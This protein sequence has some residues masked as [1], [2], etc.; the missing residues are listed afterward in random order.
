MEQL[1]EAF[2]IDLRLIIIQVFNFGILMAALT[3]FLYKPVLKMLNEREEKIAQGMKDAQ[4]AGA[5][6]AEATEEKKAVIAAANKEAEA[7]TARAKDH[8]VVK[9]DEIVADAQKK[10]EQ[11]VKDASLRGEELKTAALKASEA[12]IAKLAVLA[13][14]KVLKERAS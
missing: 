13:A 7:M 12:E 5:A 14:E 11:V 4:E 6:K 8:A 10:A 3:Y 2:G 9:A 1:I